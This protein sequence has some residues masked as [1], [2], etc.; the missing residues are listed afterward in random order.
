M[1]PDGLA[2]TPFP[3]THRNQTLGDDVQ[4]GLRILIRRRT[5]I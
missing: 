3:K 1:A 4:F 2:Y 5:E